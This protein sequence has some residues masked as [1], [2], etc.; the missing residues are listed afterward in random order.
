MKLITHIW[1][2]LYPP[3]CVF[4]RKPTKNLVC[5]YHTKNLNIQPDI[6][7]SHKQLTVLSV[8]NYRNKSVKSLI[9]QF[10]FNGIFTLSDFMAD[11]IIQ[12]FSDQIP[13]KSVL[14]PVPLHWTRRLWRGFNQANK[15]AKSIQKIRPDLQINNGLKRTKRTKQQA[16]LSKALRLSNLKDVF[17]WKGKINHKPSNIFLVDDVF[18]SG[19]TLHEAQKTMEEQGFSNVQAICFARTKQD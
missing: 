6:F 16:R 3:K 15:I 4:C 11:Q 1:D 7:M 17:E 12:K 5:K 14:V 19:I 18:T 2:I 8:S 13:V 10:K 9:S